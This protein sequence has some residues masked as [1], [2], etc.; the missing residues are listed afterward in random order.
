MKI[1]FSIILILLIFVTTGLQ[2]FYVW[3][4]GDRKTMWVQIVIMAIA[5]IGGIMAIYNE[6]TPSLAYFLNRLSPLGTGNGGILQ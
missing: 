3:K 4:K 1:L 6:N 5:M 2:L